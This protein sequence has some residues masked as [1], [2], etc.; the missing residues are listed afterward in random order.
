MDEGMAIGAKHTPDVSDAL[1]KQVK[2]V[3][4]KRF[5]HDERRSPKAYGVF[6]RSKMAGARHV[7]MAHALSDEMQELMSEALEGAKLPLV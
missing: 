5:P 1:Q 7:W 2:L 6:Y 4:K 3:V